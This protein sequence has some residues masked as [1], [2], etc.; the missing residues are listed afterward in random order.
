MSEAKRSPAEKKSDFTTIQEGDFLS[1]TQYYRVIGVS[2]DA[3][4][5]R[6]ERGYELSLERGAVEEG[7]FSAG[8][9]AEERKV[10]RTELGAILEAAGDVIFTVNFNKKVKERDVC[11][12]I[13]TGL[14]QAKLGFGEAGF[15]ELKGLIQAAVKR[16]IQGEERTLIGHLTHTAPKM[17]RS[18]VYDLQ[19]EAAHRVR[20]VDHRTLNWLILKNV[21]YVVG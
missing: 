15:K 10:T 13:F 5:A 20:L 21:K 3:I 7:M 14:E 17:G 11:D 18:E 6:N 1:E 4:Q 9:F 8:Q 16:G 19:I 2:E 12:E